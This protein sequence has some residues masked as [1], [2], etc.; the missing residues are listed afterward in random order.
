[1]PTPKKGQAP[2]DRGALASG[3][4][5]VR[6]L[7]EKDRLHAS[8]VVS[9]FVLGLRGAPASATPA[10][11]GREILGALGLMPD[12]PKPQSSEQ[13]RRAREKEAERSR[14]AA[15]TG[16][17]KTDARARS[18]IEELSAVRLDREDTSLVDPV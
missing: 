3:I 17:P 14:A 16:R 2:R 18:R 11:D 8:A 6:E 9:E 13:F 1:M 15:K 10:H 7:S 12:Q 5:V 4:P